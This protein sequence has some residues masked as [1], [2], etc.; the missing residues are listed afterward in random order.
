MPSAFDMCKALD[1]HCGVRG[2]YIISNL[3]S[4]YIEYYKVIYIDFAEQKYR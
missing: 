2:I 4:K 1:I 3:P